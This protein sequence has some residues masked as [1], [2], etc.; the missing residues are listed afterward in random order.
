[1]TTHIRYIALPIL[2]TTLAAC[3]GD[4]ITTP[5]PQ[6][7]PTE[8][9][10][11]IGHANEMPPQQA[12][13]ATMGLEEKGVK[14][15]RLWGYKTMSATTQ[16]PYN[17]SDPQNVM[18]RYIVKWQANTA[19]TTE[20]NTADWEYV[21]ISNT[22]LSNGTQTVKYWDFS[23]TSYRFFAFAP[24]DALASTVNYTYPSDHS[25][26]YTWFDITFPADA[27]HPEN[28]PYISKLW[29][30]T[31]SADTHMYGDVVNLEF[32]KPVSKVRIQLR[33]MNG[34]DISD[35]LNEQGITSLEFKP[36]GT[37]ETYIVQ[38]GKLKVSYPI[39]GPSTITYYTPTVT[40]VGDPTGTVNINKTGTGYNDWYYVLP[41]VE[42]QAF[43]L[44]ANVAGKT[45]TAVVPAAYM[46]WNP[47]MEYTYIFKLTDQEFEFIDL[48]QI[49]VTEWIVEET[50]HD[51]YNW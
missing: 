44:T 36:T 30:G 9:P 10:I 33:D 26:A 2:L 31:N 22:D 43:I 19:G 50:N 27:E 25:D 1:M 47:N 11:C 16:T 49:G 17:Y 28:A 7:V 13:R 6:P 20:S 45:K 18:D 48:I 32:M 39:T 46:S 38:S 8:N 29:F 40:I 41:H 42:Q 14:N 12:T 51:I 35:P 23:A 34:N 21:G 15:F 5:E 24:S 4:D 37:G 3:S